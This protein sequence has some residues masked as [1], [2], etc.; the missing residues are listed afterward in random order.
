[1]A[2]DNVSGAI[3][4]AHVT[5]DLTEMIGVDALSCSFTLQQ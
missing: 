4:K 3:S 2:F 1:M 5:C